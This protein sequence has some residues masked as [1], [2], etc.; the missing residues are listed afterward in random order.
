MSLRRRAALRTVAVVAVAALVAGASGFLVHA[1]VTSSAER[2]PLAE[3]ANDP[4]ISLD[5]TRDSVVMTPAS[6]PN[7]EG[8]VFIAGAKI[9]PVAYAYKLSGLVDAGY[10]VVIVRPFLNF[11]LFE[12]RPLSAFTDLAPSVS[13]WFVGGHSLGGVKACMYADSPDVRGLV[14]FGSYCANDLSDSELTVISLAGSADGLS[15]PAKIA[16]NAKTLPADTTFVEIEGANHA[17][18]GDYGLQAGDGDSSI[19]DSDMRDII[20]D[21]I[22]G[23]LP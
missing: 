11:G 5:Y 16:S 4:A 22:T 3:V 1:N 19:D 10:T 6:D 8:L 18:F 7:G 2:E 20:T 12:T 9:E 15:T 23:A 17:A 21:T 14:L 13:D